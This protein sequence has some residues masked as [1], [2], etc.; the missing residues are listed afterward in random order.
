MHSDNDGK[1]NSQNIVLGYYF[2][3]YKDYCEF[4][5]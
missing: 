4:V 5:S 3:K 1:L 2:K